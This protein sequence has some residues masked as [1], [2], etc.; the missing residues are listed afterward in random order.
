VDPRTG[1]N[2]D[3]DSAFDLNAD[4]IRFHGAKPMR[5]RIQTLNA[6]NVELLHEKYRYLN[7]HK[8]EN[9]FGFD[10]EFCTISLL[11]MLKY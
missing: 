2:A 4:R 6:Q 1:L 11:V 7:V 3:P 10:F 9:F 8:N 5:I